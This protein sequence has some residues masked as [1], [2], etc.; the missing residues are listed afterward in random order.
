M[1]VLAA[2]ADGNATKMLLWGK[3]RADAN[4]PTLTVGAPVYMSETAGDIVVAQPTTAS[5][6][7]R[8]VGFGNTADELFFCPSPD[9]IV[10][11]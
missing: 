2:G 10:H 11:T 7:I 3:I 4:F 1:C 9:Y 5:V 8:I 6:A